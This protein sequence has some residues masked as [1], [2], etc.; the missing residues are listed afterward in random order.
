M[1]AGTWYRAAHR[2]TQFAAVPKGK[3]PGALLRMGKADQREAEQLPLGKARARAKVGPL[4]LKQ[5]KILV[6]FE[7]E[8]KVWDQERAA[9]KRYVSKGF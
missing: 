4:V 5:P 9:R 3:V 1:D 8:Q 7:D 2:R 6:G